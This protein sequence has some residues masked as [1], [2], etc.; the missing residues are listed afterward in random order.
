MK[1]E[2]HTL[3]SAPHSLKNTVKIQPAERL[4]PINTQ[5]FDPSA[6]KAGS[7]DRLRTSFFTQ[8]GSKQKLYQTYLYQITHLPVK[9]EFRNQ[10]I[11]HQ[12]MRNLVP[13]PKSE[14]YFLEKVIAILEV[15]TLFRLSLLRALLWQWYRGQIQGL[16]D[17]RYD[18]CGILPRQLLRPPPG[19]MFQAHKTAPEV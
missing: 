4:K 14:Y 15:L 1:H 16:A 9:R 12:H 13:F 18:V 8:A 17:D 6:T 10:D 11:K 2:A 7:F 19:M 5:P 3:N